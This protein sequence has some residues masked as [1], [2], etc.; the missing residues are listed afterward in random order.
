[1]KSEANASS[2]DEKYRQSH[3]FSYR[4]WLYK[5]FVQ[6][7]V[8]KADLPDG[9]SVLDIGC[10][11]GFFSSLF[12]E[13]GC[14]VLGVDLSAEGIRSAERNYGYSGAAFKTGNALAL[15]EFG[16]FDCVFARGLSLYNVNDF[17][18]STTV[19]DRLLANVRPG[20]MLIFAY[21]TNLCRSKTSETW[22]YHTLDDVVR[23]FSGF[24]DAQIYFTLR[25]ETIGFRQWAFSKPIT[26]LNSIVSER[27]GV[28]GE[29]V[30][31]VRKPMRAKCAD[32]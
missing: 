22:R 10:G 32:E 26:A 8:K 1:M 29:L 20:G 13:C 24:P 21:H 15:D 27:T 30:A 31:F 28:A 16:E 2:Y 17:A 11:Q 5:P 25:I 6:A 19:S 3:Y 9:A 4:K 18:E 14:H 12:A 23:H 7:L